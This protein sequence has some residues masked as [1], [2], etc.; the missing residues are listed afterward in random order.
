MSNEKA[1]DI[2]EAQ[3]RECFG[4]VAYSHKAHEK[5][6]DIALLRLG[7][8]KIGQIVLSA[9]TT[10]GL[11]VVIFGPANVGKSSAWVAALLSTLLLVLNAYTKDLDPG[12]AAEKHK[13]TAA[14]LWNVR[15]SYLSALTDLRGQIKSLED[16]CSERD[17]LQKILAAEYASAPRTTSKAYQLASKALQFQE[18]LTFSDAE[19]DQ[20]LPPT[21][22]R[23]A[24]NK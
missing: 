17:R 16:I 7:C 23:N 5:A 9:L 15:E 10:G 21:I 4:R 12:Q 1:P 8:V 14:R 18:E 3:L 22:R 11:V 6:A 19:I 20:L 24:K 13:E 2:V